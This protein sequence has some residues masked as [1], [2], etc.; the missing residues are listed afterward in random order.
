[1]V[2]FGDKRL[3]FNTRTTHRK[4]YLIPSIGRGGKIADFFDILPHMIFDQIFSQHSTDGTQS[5]NQK[6]QDARSRN[7]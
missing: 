4:L 3:I 1:M 5:K 7:F 6:S 2:E